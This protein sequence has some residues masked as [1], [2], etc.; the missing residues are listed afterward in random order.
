MPKYEE[1][2]Q[3]GFIF[4][5]N[6]SYL[7]FLDI[8]NEQRQTFLESP[9]F[10]TIDFMA[11]SII[12][13]ACNL[14]VAFKLMIDHQN[15]F[16][17]IPFIRMQLDNAM[18]AFGMLIAKN[19]AAYFNAFAEGKPINQILV[20]PE[21][22]SQFGIVVEGKQQLTN[23]F[24]YEALDKVS[25]GASELYKR[26][27][28][29][30]HPSSAILQGSWFGLQKGV[31]EVKAWDNVKPY[32]YPLENITADY[33][34]ACSILFKVIEFYQMLK[35][36]NKQLLDGNVISENI[37]A[38]PEEISPEFNKMLELLQH[39]EED[40]TIKPLTL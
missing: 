19:E 9:H 18:M 14:D 32:G 39:P 36:N 3:R 6:D 25:E 34:K 7:S 13:S 24:I 5:I 23:R 17:A 38:K 11:K 21:L 28:S 31:L 35:Y 40:T 27:C 10:I 29:Y 30:V 2:D 20:D 4:C 37:P 15:L 26:C 8:F 12:D 16:G 33:I 22:V 1:L